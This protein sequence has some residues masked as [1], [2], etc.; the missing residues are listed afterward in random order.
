MRRHIAHSTL[1]STRA[2][3]PE[4]EEQAPNGQGGDTVVEELHLRWNQQC[5]RLSNVAARNWVEQVEITR[6]DLHFKYCC[7][8]L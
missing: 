7:W 6:D 5:P 4:R 2:K 1:C 3:D 8:N